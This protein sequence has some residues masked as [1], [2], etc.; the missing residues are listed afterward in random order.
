MLHL[1]GELPAEGGRVRG[2][3][4]GRRG[5]GDEESLRRLALIGI[6]FYGTSLPIPCP[7]SRIPNPVFGVPP[8]SPPRRYNDC[9]AP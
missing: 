4:F 5:L 9:R 2:S 6:T 7:Q 8:S 3:G 1:R